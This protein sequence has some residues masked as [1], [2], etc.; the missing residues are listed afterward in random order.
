[1]WSH[2][3]W[4]ATAKWIVT[5]VLALLAVFSL[6]SEEESVNQ[7]ASGE[8]AGDQV[9]ADSGEQ[10]QQQAASEQQPEQADSGEQEQQQQAQAASGQQQPDN[11]SGAGQQSPETPA[12][13]TVGMGQPLAV[14][15]VGWVVTDATR[16]NQL[17]QEEFG[18]FGETKQGNFVIVDFQFTNNSTEAVTLD[19]VSLALIDSQG[20]EFQT[21][22]DTFGYIPQNLDI[23]FEQVNPGVTKQGRVIFTVAPNASNLELRLGDAAFFGSEEGFVKLGF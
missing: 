14:G 10:G 23:F 19:S 8:P 1:M 5:G 3:T 17:R 2:A 6:F 11:D 4:N 20:R 13:Q 21:D 9:A 16:A 7:V 15:E 12:N 22:T 18:E